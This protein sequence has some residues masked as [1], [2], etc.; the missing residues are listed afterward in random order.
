[1]TWIRKIKP[2]KV[3][4]RG[5]SASQNFVFKEKRTKERKKE[6]HFLTS[7]ARRSIELN[8]QS[9]YLVKLLLLLLVSF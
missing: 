9:I 3:Q 4:E 2:V 5:Y 8:L 1:M 7:T 6:E